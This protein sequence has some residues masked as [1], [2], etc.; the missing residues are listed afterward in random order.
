MV[1]K[2]P[3]CLTKHERNASHRLSDWTGEEG[4]RLVL[5]FGVSGQFCSWKP[6]GVTGTKIS[7]QTSGRVVGAP[8]FACPALTGKFYFMLLCSFLAWLSACLA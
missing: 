4:G 5:G 7:L 2:E 6:L 8:S 3:D 1:H